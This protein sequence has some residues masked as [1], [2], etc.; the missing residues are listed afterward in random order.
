MFY[1]R[2]LDAGAGQAHHGNHE[3][4]VVHLVRA[5]LPRFVNGGWILTVGAVVA[6]VAIAV[7]AIVG[8]WQW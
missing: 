3:P 8:V 5:L 1:P 7:A 6:A 2:W 4:H